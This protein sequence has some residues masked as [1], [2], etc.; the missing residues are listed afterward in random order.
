MLNETSYVMSHRNDSMAK[1]LNPTYLKT[2][3]LMDP[4]NTQALR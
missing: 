1:A 4:R 3:K 2:C